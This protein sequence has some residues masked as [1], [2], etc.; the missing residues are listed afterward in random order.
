MGIQVPSHYTFRWS[1]K[2][3]SHLSLYSLEPMLGFPYLQKPQG[4]YKHMKMYNLKFLRPLP[5]CMD[6][7][8]Y[9]LY[10]SVHQYFCYLITRT[11]LGIFCNP[12]FMIPISWVH[13]DLH[14]RVVLEN[15]I[16]CICTEQYSSGKGTTKS[17][18]LRTQCWECMRTLHSGNYERGNWECPSH[19]DCTYPS[20]PA[21]SERKVVS[22]SDWKSG[23]SRNP[24]P[25]LLVKIQI[26]R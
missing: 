6:T 16:E 23:T 26:S 3:L 5:V 17:V 1:L 24:V 7:A 8:F 25:I 12:R 19:R 13:C 20:P 10:P 11:C 9:S 15:W 14:F 18:W 21:P 22:P 2:V 4:H